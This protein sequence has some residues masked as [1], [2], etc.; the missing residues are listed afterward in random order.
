MKWISV[1]EKLPSKT[2]Q[3]EVVFYANPYEWWTGVFTPAG[4]F[5]SKDNVFQYHQHWGDDKYHTI[6]N[7]THWLPLPEPPSS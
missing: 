5:N 6:S 2:E 3:V 1:N 7:V 4:I